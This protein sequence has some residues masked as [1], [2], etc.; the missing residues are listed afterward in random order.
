M[1]EKIK[2]RYSFIVFLEQNGF[3]SVINI[4]LFLD[5]FNFPYQVAAV[6]RFLTYRW[7]ST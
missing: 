7:F 1:F 4:L 6:H 5:A 2:C 3:F